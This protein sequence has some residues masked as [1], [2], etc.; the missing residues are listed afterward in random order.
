MRSLRVTFVAPFGVRRRGTT[1]ARVIPL[2]KALAELGHCVRVVIPDW[3]CPADA[4]R[5]YR[6]GGADIVHLGAPGTGRLLLSPHLLHQTYRAALAGQPDVIHCFKPIG[7]SGAV[8]LLLQGRARNH[9]WNGML[10]VDTDDLEGR[11]GWAN[12]DGR[13]GWQVSVLEYQERAVVRAADLLTCAS[14]TLVQ[15]ARSQRPGRAVPTYLPNAVELP[16]CR[17]PGPLGEAS[18][19]IP[20]LLIYTRFNEFT[21]G[22]AAAIVGEILRGVPNAHLDVVGDGPTL[23]RHSFF[24]AIRRQGFAGRVRERGLL[25]GAQLSAALAGD[26]VALWLFDN[27]AINRARSPAKLLELL[28]HGK[29]IVAE[30]VGEVARQVGNAAILTGPDAPTDT[31]RA[32]TSLLLTREHRAALGHKA[33]LRARDSARWHSRATA[34]NTA[35]ILYT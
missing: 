6:A 14:T 29:A 12:R 33:W 31:I 4:G 21:P 27:N 34:L 18:D 35:Y 9:G 11:A 16:D 10:A 3:D 28:A 2:A 30:S 26:A 5:R 17:G 8:A 22:R 15:R 20:S 25:N 13:P 24:G 23:E 7:Y 1:Q 32:T 19:C